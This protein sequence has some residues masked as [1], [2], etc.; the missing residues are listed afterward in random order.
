MQFIEI[1]TQFIFRYVTCL[2]LTALETFEVLSAVLMKIP[3][4]VTPC[5]L[6]RTYRRF[7]GG[8]CLHL[9]G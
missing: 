4:N 8:K 7:E 5:R 9:Q 6:I 3:W 2:I 1:T